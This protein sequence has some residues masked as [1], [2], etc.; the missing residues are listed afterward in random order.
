MRTP[1]N[2]LHVVKTSINPV[3][4]TFTKCEA[5]EHAGQLLEHAT[6]LPIYRF[7]YLQWKS[8]KSKILKALLVFEIKHNLIV[9]SSCLKEDNAEQSMAG[10]FESILNV[11]HAEDEIKDAIERVFASYGQITDCDQIFVQPQLS[12]VKL[13][14]V[15]F[16]FEPNS[17]A[18]Y[19]VIN[20]DDET[21]STESI[22]SGASQNSKTEFISHLAEIKAGWQSN[23][24]DAVKQ[25]QVIFQIDVLD[26]EFAID[27]QDILYIFQVRPL[28][29][30]HQ[31]ERIN[32]SQ[33][34]ELNCIAKKVY[35]LS[36]PHPYLLGQSTVFGVMP[37][38]NPAEIIGIK[39]KPLALSLYKELVTDRIWSHQRTN[40]GY[41]D[42]NGFPLLV[43]LGGTPYI[44]VRLSFNSFIPST[45]SQQLAEKLVNFYLNKLSANPS[46]H[47]KIEFAIVYSCYSFDIDNRLEELSSAGFSFE[48]ISQIKQSLLNL[49]NNIICDNSEIWRND[50][51]L[52]EALKTKQYLI[53]NSHLNKIE[54]IHWLIED[55]KNYGTLPFAGLARAGFIAIQ[56]LESLISINAITREDGN[57]FLKSVT[58][59]S[60]KML[61]DFEQLDQEAFLYIY[62]HLRPGTYDILSARYDEK[63]DQYFDWG[64][65]ATEHNRQQNS[66]PISLEKLNTINTILKQQGIEIEAIGLFNFIKGAIEARELGKFVFSKSLSDC[67]VL[68]E[69]LGQ[70][71]GFSKEN[72]AFTDIRDI[73]KLYSTSYSATGTLASSVKLGKENYLIAKTIHLPA[74]IQH[75]TDVYQFSLMQDQANFITQNSIT[76]SVV[77]LHDNHSADLKGKILF[78]ESADPG[79]DWIF[80]QEIAGFVTKYGGCNSHMAIRAGE[81]NLPAIIGAGELQF[82]RWGRAEKL[83]IDCAN[84]KVDLIR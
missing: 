24:I 22:T 1:N 3:S 36:C 84:K 12:N 34:I 59:V 32:S 41:R 75:P 80:S 7:T 62:G 16:S 70:G 63:P 29:I 65:P 43:V 81:L 27:K 56:L 40:Y 46:L 68:I 47:D 77:N 15:I 61:Q 33:Q 23:L 38:W 60:S 73:L 25:L 69:Q 58:T 53:K 71:M 21:S 82:A 2:N 5:L 64:S 37:D 52:I 57:L 76:A 78:I 72:M 42:V 9:R 51:A 4:F 26:I 13:S 28:L 44:D 79:Y 8:E 49:T 45:L 11:T 55:C 10:C 50:I 19:F 6:V 18:H 14:G 35:R 83:Y 17:G 20:Y 66:F 39:P 48:E 31:V 30:G 67:L 74:L 54:K